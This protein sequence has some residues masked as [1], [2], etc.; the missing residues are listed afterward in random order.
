[1]DRG[2]LLVD[3]SPRELVERFA[4]RHVIEVAEPREDLRAWVRERGLQFDDLGHRLII[5]GNDS[6]SEGLFRE[7][8]GRCPGD[9]CLLRMATL[10]DVFLKLTDGATGMS[11]ISGRFGGCGGAISP[12]TAELDGQF[13]TPDAGAVL[14][15]LAFGVGFSRLV[16]TSPMEGDRFYTLFLAPALVAM[17]VMNNAFFENTYGSF[18]RMYYQKTFDAMMATPLS[19]G[20]HHRR[21]RLGSTKPSSPRPSCCS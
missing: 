9:G 7:V 20:D 12:S 3:G 1:M 13:L 5:F 18:V 6:D 19:L 2:K 11:A 10:E 16:G 8:A 21:D 17:T 15:L 14:Y 4:G